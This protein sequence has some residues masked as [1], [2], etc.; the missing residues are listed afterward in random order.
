MGG[1]TASVEDEVP[2]AGGAEAGVGAAF[3]CILYLLKGFR[4]L[5]AASFKSFSAFLL[6]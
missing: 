3:D 4:R 5:G 2:K 1:D 6:L